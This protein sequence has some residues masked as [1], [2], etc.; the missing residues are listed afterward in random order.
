MKVLANVTGCVFY[1]GLLGFK[2]PPVL[3]IAHVVSFYLQR[4]RIVF[5][6]GLNKGFIDEI[7]NG[8]TISINSCCPVSRVQDLE[9]S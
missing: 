8:T 6:K 7:R 3:I 9:W 1:S 2:M 5:P 4:G